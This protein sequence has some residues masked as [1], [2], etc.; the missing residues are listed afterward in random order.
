MTDHNASSRRPPSEAS[1]PVITYVA[2]DRNGGYVVRQKIIRDSGYWIFTEGQATIGPIDNLAAACSQSAIARMEPAYIHK[3]YCEELKRDALRE[4]VEDARWGGPKLST[5]TEVIINGVRCVVN[6][7][8][9]LELSPPSSGAACPPYPT[10]AAGKS[11]LAA[12][13]RGPAHKLG[14]TRSGTIVFSGPPEWQCPHDLCGVTAIASGAAH[15][16]ALLKDGSVRAWGSGDYG[17]ALVPE[18]MLNVIAIAAHGYRSIVMAVDGP[19]ASSWTGRMHRWGRGQFDIGARG[20]SRFDGRPWGAEDLARVLRDSRKSVDCVAWVRRVG[21]DLGFDAVAGPAHALI[22]M[23]GGEVVGW[24]GERWDGT[25]LNTPTD[26]GPVARI[27]AGDTWSAVLLKDGSSRVWGRGCTGVPWKIADPDGFIDMHQHGE[28]TPEFAVSIVPARVVRGGGEA[29]LLY[30]DGRVR[31]MPDGIRTTSRHTVPL[32]LGPVKELLLTRTHSTA[33]LRDGSVRAWGDI[34]IPASSGTLK[35]REI[36]SGPGW[37]AAR[38]HDGTSVIWGTGCDSLPWS[39]DCPEDFLDSCH[40]S[41]VTP[42]YAAS[43]TNAEV[44]WG[45]SIALVSHP[46]GRVHLLAQTAYDYKQLKRVTPW[47]RV[48]TDVGAIA[49]VEFGSWHVVALLADGTV[50]CWGSNR[51]TQCD[52]PA[53]LQEVVDIEAFPQSAAALTRDGVVAVWGK[54]CVPARLL[55]KGLAITKGG[56]AYAQGSKFAAVVSPKGKVTCFGKRSDKRCEVPKGL[57]PV[58]DIVIGK[59]HIVAR[60]LNGT[61]RCWGDNACGQ[62]KPPPDIHGVSLIDASAMVS[63]CVDGNDDIHVWGSLGGLERLPGNASDESILR[64]AARYLDQVPRRCFPSRI[65]SHPQFK[66]MKAL[67]RMTQGSER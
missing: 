34:E 35:A 55:A 61:V 67:R 3:V 51:Y 32:D 60:L 53:G 46:S 58:A 31:H 9:K 14:L 27:A 64:F 23:P 16:L 43:L 12:S 18:D 17:N 4:L 8:G 6:D 56:T 62:C 10:T 59:D 52:V 29:A 13:S 21:A 65:L 39:I 11:E 37:S 42:R 41:A 40:Y 5:G 19:A 2:R 36:A 47:V 24:T 57:E 44:T 22:L 26:L 49:R 1:D 48:P 15:C 38:L 50:Q 25:P 45:G 33:L 7:S 30:P 20:I 28:I 66:A 54:Q 63:L